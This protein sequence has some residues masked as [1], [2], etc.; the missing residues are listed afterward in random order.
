MGMFSSIDI[1]STGLTAQRLRM[2]V[3]SD[4]IANAT[5]T[6]TTEGGAFVKS[7]VILRARNDY[8]QFKTPVMPDSFK[9]QVGTGVR[10]IKIEKDHTTPLKW[11]Y[12]PSHPDA[13]KTGEKKGYVAM[14]NI[15]VVKE[16]VDMISASRAYEANI[17]MVNSAKSMFRSALDIGK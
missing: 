15:S 13:V 2:D 11:V 16:M 6:R 1:A 17:S 14:P 10:V 4:N 12:N 3:I 7:Q 8:A 5:T 9:P